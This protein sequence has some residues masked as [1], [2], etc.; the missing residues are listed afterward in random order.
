M[1]GP[2]RHVEIV[3]RQDFKA[4]RFRHLSCKGSRPGRVTID[5]IGAREAPHGGQR[6][7]LEPALPPASAYR[8]NCGIPAREVA[9]RDRMPQSS[10]YADADGKAGSNFVRWPS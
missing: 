7:K 10:R 5:G 8:D 4:E 6:A 9:R 2:D 3:G 1:A